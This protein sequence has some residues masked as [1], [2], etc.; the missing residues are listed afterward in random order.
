M[1]FSLNVLCH[2]TRKLV[3][4]ISHFNIYIVDYLIL[5]KSLLVYPWLRNL[6]VECSQH[7]IMLV[8]HHQVFVDW[9]PRGTRGKSDCVVQ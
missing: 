2:S 3:A 4:I 7:C 6:C 1:K 8:P 9:S 5:R